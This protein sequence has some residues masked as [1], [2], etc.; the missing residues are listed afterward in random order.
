MIL[1]T[2]LEAAIQDHGPLDVELV[3]L[4]GNAFSV[5]GALHR[6]AR[7]QGWTEAERTALNDALTAGDYDHLLQ[8]A[9]EVT[10]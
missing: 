4:D 6:Q 5:I 10:G 2:E 3:G 8:V 7:R 1:D 9:I